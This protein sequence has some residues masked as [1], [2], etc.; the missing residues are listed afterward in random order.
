MSLILILD[1]VRS[2]LNV[3]AIFRSADAFAIHS[4]CLC[5]ITVTPPHPEIMKTALGANESVD[6]KYF[7]T[8]LQAIEHVKAAGYKAVAIEQTDQ[9][10]SLEKLNEVDFWPMAIIFGNEMRGISEAILKM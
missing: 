2:G 7:E 9:S 3:G 5:G 6:W 4:I 10:V 1:N 8:T